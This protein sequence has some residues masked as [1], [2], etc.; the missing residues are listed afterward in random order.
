MTVCA[1]NC[2]AALSSQVPVISSA[3]GALGR[4]CG[5]DVVTV[6]EVECC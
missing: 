4:D 5:L 6:R 3:P 1:D 2:L